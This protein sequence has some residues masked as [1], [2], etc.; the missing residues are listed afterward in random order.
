MLDL[1]IQLVNYKSLNFTKDCIKSIIK[2]LEKNNIPFDIHVLDNNSEKIDEIKNINNQ[3]NVYY[4]KNN[5]G[6]GAAHNY[7]SNQSES[8]YI[9]FVNPDIR[10][11]ETD[12]ISSLLNKL[13]INNADII[14]PK[15]LTSNYQQ[16]QYDHGDICCLYA[17]ILDLFGCTYWQKKKKACEANWVPASCMLVRRSVF[18]KLDGFDEKIFLYNEGK[19]FCFRARKSGY[20]IY[21]CPTIKVI[22][23]DSIQ[24]KKYRLIESTKYYLQKKYQNKILYRLILLLNLFHLKWGIYR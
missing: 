24:E 21:Y 11:F 5:T 8:K 15:Q 22:H 3:I 6:P 10:F 20:K 19:E 14:G 4:S 12:S 2:D 18:V 7:L 17:K 16:L 23:L 13:L 9:L 1:T